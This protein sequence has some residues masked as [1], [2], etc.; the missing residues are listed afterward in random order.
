MMTTEKASPEV[1]ERKDAKL[2][3]SSLEV[4]STID[5]LPH[6]TR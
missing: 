6:L 4:R 1:K 5:A 2:R 3:K